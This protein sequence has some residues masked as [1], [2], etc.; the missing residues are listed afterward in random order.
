MDLPIKAVFFDYFGV[1]SSEGYW[2]LVKEDK[3]VG[4]SFADLA[5]RMNSGELSWVDFVAKIAQLTNQ[6]P[7][8]VQRFYEAERINPEVVALAD[9]LHGRYVTGII[10]NASNEF[11]AP[12]VTKGKLDHVFDHIIVS[13]EIG[14]AKPDAY[15]YREACRRAGVQPEEAVFIDDI[16]RNVDGAIRVGMRAVVFTDVPRLKLDLAKIGVR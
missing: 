4:G 5:K 7:A 8:D 10:S 6:T 9:A 15:I 11:F 16:A 12:L 2:Q 14:V 1:I 3:N 13:S